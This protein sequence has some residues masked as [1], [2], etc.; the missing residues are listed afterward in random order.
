MKTN[1]PSFF[2]PT[3]LQDFNQAQGRAHILIIKTG[4]A[5]DVLRTT[6][7]LRRRL[8][9]MAGDGNQLH[10]RAEHRRRATGVHQ[11]LERMGRGNAPGAGPPVRAGLSGSYP[12]RAGGAALSGGLK[13]R[14]ATRDS[15]NR[16][17]P[18][19]DRTCVIRC[20]SSDIPSRPSGWCAT[21]DTVGAR[22]HE[23][24]QGDDRARP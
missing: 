19:Q 12:K 3:A 15:M 4:A 21:I 5:G 14:T 13:G 17:T 16:E 6:P 23:F 1:S 22:Q 2:S 11:C 7:L 9:G 18:I 10:A 8:S 24:D 20:A